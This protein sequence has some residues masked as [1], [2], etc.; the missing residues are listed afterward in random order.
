M[1]LKPTYSCLY[2]AAARRCFND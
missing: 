2:V 1:Q